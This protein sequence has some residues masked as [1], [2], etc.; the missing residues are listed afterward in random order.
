MCVCKCELI[1]LPA[2]FLRG[3]G[4]GMD[5]FEV[6]TSVINLEIWCSFTSVINLEL[7]SVRQ[8]STE[9]QCHHTRLWWGGCVSKV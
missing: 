2:L 9:L 6:S 5:L 7:A 1:S 8:F 3:G 4:V